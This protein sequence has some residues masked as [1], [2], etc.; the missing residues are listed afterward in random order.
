MT[1][2]SES[3]SPAPLLDPNAN[4]ADIVAQMT[5]EEKA[6]LCSGQ[7]FWHTKAIERL[8]VPSFMMT[9]G[10]HGLRK[11]DES[12]DHL[13]INQS[14][15]A[16]CFP[17]ACTT[18]CS[19]DRD[20]LREVGAAIGK[21]CRQEEVTAILG[22][23]LNIKRSPLCGRNFEYFSE[24]PLLSGA[25]AAALTEGI[26]SKNV[27]ACPKH[28]ALN[29]QEA[30]RMVADSVVDERAKREIYYRGYE[31][32]VRKANPWMIMCSY[33]RIDGIYACENEDLLTDSLRDDWGFSGAVVT[34]WGATN[35]RVE[36]AKAGLDLQMP[37]DEGYND[38][39]LVEAVHEGRLEES[40]L[41]T[42]AERMVA[43]SQLAA[44]NAQTSITYSPSEH[45]AIARNAAAQS[46]VLLKNESRLLPIKK[47][48]KIAVIGQFAKKPRYQG[49]G[50]S[51]IVPTQLESVTEALEN[52]GIAY[53]YADGYSLEPWSD[54][55][56]AL[57]EEARR[58]ALAN[59]VVLLFVGLPG[60]Y[61]S[62][63]F[64]RKSLDMPPSH[65]KL[66]ESICAANPNTVVVLQ[67]GAPVVM[68]WQNKARSI[69]LAYLGGQAGGSGCVDVLFGDVNPSGHL[70]ESWPRAL[71]DTAC[72]RYFPGNP[73]SVEY[74]ESIFV[75]YRFYDITGCAPAWPF[76]HGLSYT[77]FEYSNLKLE[78]NSFEPGDTL[79]VSLTVKNAGAVAGADVVQL[80]VSKPESSIPR[81]AKELQGFEKVYLEPGESRTVT[82]ELGDRAFTYYNAPA[83][84]W[85]FEEGEYQIMIG[86]SSREIVLQAPVQ[87]RGDGLEKKLEQLRTAAPE[88]F[89]LAQTSC[90]K[91]GFSVADSSFEA[92]LGRPLPPGN[93]V[94]GEPFTVNSTFADAQSKFI[95]RLIISAAQK[96]MEEMLGDNEM[97]NDMAQAMFMEMPLR[98]L[99][100]FSNGMLNPHQVEGLVDVM[101]GKLFQGLKKL[102]NKG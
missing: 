59:E 95:G 23:G 65:N 45:H 66:I 46:C 47:S 17:P 8:G 13:G 39:L 101:N 63:G 27:A 25:M 16:T 72:Y 2:H 94:P 35:D 60:E 31:D 84:Q 68:P 90:S 70:S 83:E 91:D 69:L 36:A 55:D 14:V 41:D 24:D 37:A 10:P 75:G 80:Y 9:D 40:V 43:L 74:R 53:D 52:Q 92:L 85:A 73:K 12:A 42:L 77:S 38:A 4:P 79:K 49:I 99:G 86:K 93:R 89:T 28:Y 87:V 54:T 44:E 62:E 57:I 50:S 18:A 97:M 11:Q 71:S 22:P 51:I 100:M 98:A 96:Q 58:I 20:L 19:F 5:L 33:N 30:N 32:L 81:A 48:A 76:G 34:D 3:P 26:Q 21:E 7:D 15:P 82:L 102:R 78:R 29:N 67:L 61:E 88:Y 56:D 64:D 6:S 1:E